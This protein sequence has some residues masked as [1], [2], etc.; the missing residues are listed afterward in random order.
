[1]ENSLQEETKKDYKKDTQARDWVFTVNNPKLTESE[2]FEYLKTLVNVK[3]FCFGREKGD[4]TDG[5]PQGTEHQQGYIEFS[6]PKKFSTVKGY[7]SESTI[8]VNGNIQPR[9][10]KRHQARDYVYKTGA[11]ADKA[12][13]KI[14]DTYT[15]GEFVDDGERSDIL[16]LKELVD[17]GVSDYELGNTV[18][19]AYARHM[20][21]VDRRRQINAYEKFGKVRRLDLEVTYIYGKA[22]I[23]KTRRVMDEYGDENVYR[24][25]DYDGNLFD[26]YNNEN[27]VIFEEFRSQVRI[28]IMLN[29]LD[30]YPLRLPARYNNKIACFTKV[31]IITNLPLSAQ[32]QNVQREHPETWQAFLRRIHKVYDFDK[33]KDIPVS[34]RTGDTVKP[35]SHLKPLSDEEADDLPF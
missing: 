28:D 19:K 6:M 17:A 31:F 20:Q 14:S 29:Y 15:H 27:V 21:F 1:M 24:I 33:S 32:Y 22:G 2:F 18:C 8:G 4:G 9:Q 25:T 16:Q 10:G 30:V 35:L 26:N 23:G 3:Y 34:K 11:Y 12:H 7:F 13:T 5:N